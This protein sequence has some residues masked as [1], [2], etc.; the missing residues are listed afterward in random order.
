MS[1]LAEL[2]EAIREE[3]GPATWSAG[4]AL[5][6]A[7]VVSVQSVDEEEV[8]LRVRIPGRPTPLT[9]TL[10]PEDEIWECDCRGK[11]DP[12]EHV[13]AA[14]IVLRQAEG[15]KATAAASPA[16]PGPASTA[17]RPGAA[18]K[19]ER[20][21]Y[22]FKRVDG[23]LQ[24]ERL[25]VRPDNTARL[26]AR[27]LA[28]V[29]QNPVEAARIHVDPCDLL[30][31]K[32]LA[33]PTRGA[34]PQSKLDALL[35]VLEKART[36][37]FDGAFVS[38]SSEPLL[39]RVTVDDR[40][41]QTV[42]KVEKDPRI[43]ELVSPGVALAAGALCRLGE[44]TL[45][46]T[47]LENLPQERVFSPEQLAD[48]TGKVL[49]DFARRMPVDVKSRR[50]PPIDR[51]LKPR[52]S[53]ELDKLDTGL[54]VLPTLVYGSP[55]TARI[56]NG[57]L[58]YLQGA[59]PVRDEPTETKLIHQLRDEL[60]MSPGRRVTVHGKEA[61]Q[62]ADKLR[63]WRG[64]LTGNAA[65]VVSPDVKLKPLL[66]LD[67]AT[68]DAGVP[69]VGFSLDFQVEG[70]GPGE[71]RTVDAGAVM[72]AWEEGLGL[73]PLE[74]GGWAPLPTGWLKAHGQRVTD[75][76][77]ARERDGRLANHAIPQLTGL[78]EALEHPAPPVME[79]LAPLVQGFE[80]LPEP[81]LPRDLTATLRPYQLQG[82]SWL[83]FLR[84]AGLGGVLADDM[85]LGKTLQTICTLGRGT[86]VVAPTSVLPNW[87]AEVK[88]FRP[89]L[90]VSVYHGVGR[91]LDESADVTLTTYAL[92]RLDA[93]ILASKTWDTVVLDEAQA[94]KNPD[95]QVARAAYE[96]DAGFRI[97]LSGTPIENRLE[98][99]WSLMHFTN[100][101]LLGGRKAFEERW[102][103]PVSE[104]Q[105]G[106]A[107]ALRARIRPFVLRRLKRDVAPELPPRTEAVRHVTLTEQERAVY[108]AVHAA[109]REEVV[110]QL[111]EGGSV[112]KA[113]EALLRLRQAACHP[114]LVP[115]QQART[116]SKVQALVEAL[117][118]AVADGHKALVFSQWTS[119]LDLIEPA[120]NEADIGFI[121]LDGSTA[122]RGA[123]ATS[124]QDEKGAPVMLISLK[125]GAT[126]LNLTAADHVFL[127]DP[128][129]NPSVEAQAADRAHRIGQQRPVM[130]YRMVSQGTVEEKILLLQEKKRALFEAALGG[131]TGGAAL[132]RADLMQLL[133]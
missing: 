33:Q 69:R 93:A 75:L 51:T 92:L 103:R 125:A 11:V 74:G 120:L 70:L 47:R 91:T 44:Q 20:L 105:K 110:S 82:V 90:K 60:N 27:S 39:P 94:I 55:P 133:D 40:G 21:V 16:R 84:Q 25:V 54:S 96:L 35:H 89:S 8:V 102:A 22:R 130:V 85:G 49:P 131:A 100:R 37:M 86:L 77:A 29:L 2:L 7:G 52:I 17:A 98:E 95:S 1:A 9:T 101:G 67:T 80:K 122:N 58:V 81:Q 56:D 129:W 5:S 99:L 62:L 64:G 63:K 126:G 65:G 78:C 68:T 38:V 19:P 124:F 6:R 3:S 128:W 46:G 111:E 118:T 45:T 34:L 31:D 79:R 72:R 61:V 32:L 113:L 28:S 114:A 15:R 107:E 48:L 117:G 109:T 112:M 66:T 59:A 88:R 97:A 71:K 127:V 132:T 30:A 73:V 106:A 24:L 13:I 10:Y 115:G 108:D 50:L 87:E 104:N 36:V 83:T 57:R 123:V 76:L 121:R 4:Q 43:N 26:L 53:L 119:M 12:C 14:A 18:P 42:L 23:G 116:S 41:E